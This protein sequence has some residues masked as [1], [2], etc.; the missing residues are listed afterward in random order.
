MRPPSHV[1]HLVM[2]TPPFITHVYLKLT[3]SLSALAS[4]IPLIASNVF[5]G[6]KATAS[7]V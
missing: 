5:L 6:A 3:A 7:T 1:R 4:L 2:C